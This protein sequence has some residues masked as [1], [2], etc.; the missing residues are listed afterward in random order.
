MTH[1]VICGGG[2]IGLLTALLLARRELE[3]TIVERDEPVDLDPLDGTERWLAASWGSASHARTCFSRQDQQGSRVRTTRRRRVDDRDAASGRSVQTSAQDTTT[4]CFWRGG[5][6]S[7]PCCGARPVKIIG[8]T[9]ATVPP[10][11][12]SWRTTG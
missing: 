7:S 3:V 11:A 9:G 6:S 1:V 8:S 5:R 10:T 12:T 2:V 4:L